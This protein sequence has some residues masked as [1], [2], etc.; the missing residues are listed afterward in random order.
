[1]GGFVIG[2]MVGWFATWAVFSISLDDVERKYNAILEAKQACEENL[3]RNI[4]CVWAPP[5]GE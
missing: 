2:V 4:E 3:P 5:A 1:M